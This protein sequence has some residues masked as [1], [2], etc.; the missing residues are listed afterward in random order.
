MKL[1][2]AQPWTI[3]LIREWWPYMSLR[4]VLRLRDYELRSSREEEN[5]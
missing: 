3:S 2:P 5:R 4:S 1:I